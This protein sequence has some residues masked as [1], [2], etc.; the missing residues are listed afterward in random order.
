MES[1]EPDVF[2]ALMKAGRIKSD[3]GRLV[4]TQPGE[5]LVV[6]QGLLDRLMKATEPDRAL[7]RDI[8]WTVDRKAAQRAYWNGATGIPKPMGD[9]M[10]E[11][12][13]K[14]AVGVAA[15]S[16]TSS[17]HS[18][19][20]LVPEQHRWLVG[21]GIY[22]QYFATVSPSWP[23]NHGI[24]TVEVDSYP[25]I[26]LSAAAIKGHIAMAKAGSPLP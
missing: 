24:S 13:G 19:L 14:Y 16:Y 9:V 5:G 23:N 18:A 7:D 15:P 6:M 12:L 17:I 3:G 22:V 8:W 11:G 20:L 4:V 21:C 10:P 2:A 1:D 26:A 25:A